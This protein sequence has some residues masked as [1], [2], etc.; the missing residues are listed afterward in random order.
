MVAV[1][2]LL[3]GVLSAGVIAAT[4]IAQEPL[5]EP[6][7]TPKELLKQEVAS[8]Q[9]SCRADTQTSMA[10]ELRAR[11]DQS[12]R[13]WCEATRDLRRKEFGEAFVASIKRAEDGGN[14][15]AKTVAEFIKKHPDAIKPS[16][17]NTTVCEDAKLTID[18]KL[19]APVIN[20]PSI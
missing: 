1:R 18:E 2:A 12:Q 14:G 9:R 6:M 10:A 11:E 8:L 16:L 3:L 13:T 15:R 7:L 17:A 19:V 5:V 20:D 4:T